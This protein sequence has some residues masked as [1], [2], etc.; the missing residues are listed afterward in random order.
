M[1]GVEE[2]V[3]IE[4]QRLGSLFDLNYPQDHGRRRRLV[5]FGLDVVGHGEEDRAGASTCHRNC[6]RRD[7][8]GEGLDALLPRM[9]A[10][11]LAWL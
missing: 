5:G 3:D 8:I 10:A 1:D 7:V 2:R 4:E 6:H 9:S 11:T